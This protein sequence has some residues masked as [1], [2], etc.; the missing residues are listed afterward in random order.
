[1]ITYYFIILTLSLF[2]VEIS[3]VSVDMAANLLYVGGGLLGVGVLDKY[4]ETKVW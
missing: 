2:R 3:A 1:M 4:S